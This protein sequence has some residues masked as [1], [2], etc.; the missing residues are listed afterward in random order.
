MEIGYKRRTRVW[1]GDG[2]DEHVDGDAYPPTRGVLVMTKAT[3]SPSGREVS[4]ARSSCRSSSLDLLK[5]RLVAAA[6]PR[7]S[8]RIIFFHTKTLHIAKEGG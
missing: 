8:S 3:I 7:K 4:L 5:F 2:V 6:K 1:R